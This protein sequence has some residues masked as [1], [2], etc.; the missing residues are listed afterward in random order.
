MF[1][2]ELSI[3]FSKTEVISA[4]IDVD[5][6]SAYQKLGL[7]RILPLKSTHTSSLKS[8]SSLHKVSII[9]SALPSQSQFMYGHEGLLGSLHVKTT[10]TL[11]GFSPITLAQIDSP[12]QA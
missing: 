9:L 1:Q 2:K 4:I 3:G 12:M 10:E 6:R 11:T 7:S 5:L 8:G